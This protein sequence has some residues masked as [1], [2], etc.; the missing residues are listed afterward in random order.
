MTPIIGARRHSSTPSPEKPVRSASEFAV[1]SPRGLPG[2]DGSN[3]QATMGRMSE[4]GGKRRWDRPDASMSL[5]ADLL[6]DSGLDP[7]YER[8]AARRAASGERTSRGFRL[9]A[10]TLLLG[11]LGAIAVVQ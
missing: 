10:A 6:S 9:L 1:T 2:F 11:L 7:G 3:G 5:L 8:A 4:Q